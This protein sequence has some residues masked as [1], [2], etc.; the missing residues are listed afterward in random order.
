MVAVAGNPLLN[1]VP[2]ATLKGY[3]FTIFRKGKVEVRD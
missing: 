1:Q 2:V 3:N